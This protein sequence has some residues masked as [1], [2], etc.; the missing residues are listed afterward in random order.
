M[1]FTNSLGYSM[2]ETPPRS[3][4]RIAAGYPLRKATKMVDLSGLTTE[5]R[6]PHTINLDVM[7]PL[8]V[9]EAMNQEDAQVA[10]AVGQVV[11]EVAQAITWGRA[12]LKARGRIVYFGAG[13]SGRL[14]L[15]DAVECR[16]TFGVTDNVVIGLIAGGQQAFV[17]AVEG[18][19]DDPALGAADLASIDLGPADLAIGIAASG[20]T[21]Y[22]LGGLDYARSQGC[23]TVA[24]ACTPGSAVGRA[25]DLA[26][27][28]AC[29]PE[30]LCGST[31]LKAGTAQKMILN[32]ISTGSLVGLGKAFSNLM[33]DV[34][35]TNDKLRAR[36]VR[37]V[38]EATGLDA[39]KAQRLLAEAHY[40]PKV[41]IVMTLAQ[42]DAQAA[43][44]YLDQAS[45]QVREALRLAGRPVG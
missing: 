37:I 18:A 22:V 36:S 4:G 33:V 8:E 19:E 16:P 13:T 26:I 17:K 28:P 7:T 35:P 27:E 10:A 3:Q 45:G 30:V 1:A 25:A 32:M 41:A 38:A 6:N 24:I 34:Q 11:P 20:R 2:A 21:P 39:E 15:L 42:V 9:A 5:G 29:G 31:R 44:G 14:G 23:K 40:Y 43:Q 12:S